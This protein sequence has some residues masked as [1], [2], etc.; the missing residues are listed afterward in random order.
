MGKYLLMLL[1][2]TPPSIHQPAEAKWAT[3]ETATFQWVHGRTYQLSLEKSGS[4]DQAH[5]RLRIKV[6]G[7][8]DF[9]LVVPG[10]VAKLS[11]VTG[12]QKLTQD[13]LLEST[14]LY[15]TPKLKD[16]L[17]RPMLVMF[18]WAYGSDPGSLHVLSLDRSGYP[19]NVFSSETF[20]LAAIKDLDGDGISELVGKHCLSQLWGTCF[21]TYDPFSVYRLSQTTSGKARLS[22]PLSRKYDEKNYYGWAGPT[23]SEEIAVVLCAPRGKPKIMSANEAKRL[24][25]K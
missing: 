2:L 6:P 22:L 5:V 12:D 25:G 15:L 7:R 19:T 8:H 10:D 17:G 21:S 13:N 18:G 11:E 4:E 20:E 23:C 24:Y 14:Y 1:M 3:L 9:T 16:H